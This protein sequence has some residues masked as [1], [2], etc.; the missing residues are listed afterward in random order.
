VSLYNETDGENIDP[1]QVMGLLGVV[2][3]LRT[4]PPGVRQRDGDV[5]L[6]LGVPA[7]DEA[8]SLAG[9]AAVWAA[10]DRRGALPA[11]D[12]PAIARTAELVRTLV[13]AGRLAGVHAVSAGGL[14]DTLAELAI[15]GEVGARITG[16]PT[17]QHLFTE[18]PGAVVAAVHPDELDAVLRDAADAG[19]PATE[20]GRAGGTTLL[21]GGEGDTL[22]EVGL[23]EL[24][25]AW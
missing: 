22:V 4:P 14:A 12:G 11:F 3:D 5:L 20:I 1:T 6:L 23:S 13:A 8:P 10:G 2:D 18:R 7:D 25:L 9:S 15:G 24:I 17:V 16:V 21:I 19:V